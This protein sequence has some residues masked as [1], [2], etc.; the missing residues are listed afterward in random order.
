MISKISKT[1]KQTKNKN[2][3]FIQNININIAKKLG[4]N[5]WY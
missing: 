2:G 3:S 1:R 4:S 5:A